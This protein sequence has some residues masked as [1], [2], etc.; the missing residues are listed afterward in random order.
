M[1]IG[2]TNIKMQD[3]NRELG[4]SDFFQVNI[5]PSG[6]GSLI[7]VL[8]GKPTGQVR[9]SDFTGKT[10]AKHWGGTL[11]FDSCQTSSGNFI[12]I[13]STIGAVTP[14][15]TK[16]RIVLG[17]SGSWADPA[18]LYEYYITKGTAASYRNAGF[19]GY[20]KTI[21]QGFEYNGDDQIY[22]I[23][24]YTGD[25]TNFPCSRQYMLT[26]QL[27]GASGLGSGSRQVGG[28]LSS[29]IASYPRN[30]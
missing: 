3:V 17:Q 26:L 6:S 20:R 25:S 10:V 19:P 21:I 16:F 15:G 9:W 27:L 28:S 4:N 5:T 22:Q 7:R 30:F 23:G 18:P 2:S 13:N 8:A 11:S 1:A 12:S 29:Y 24:Y 14:V